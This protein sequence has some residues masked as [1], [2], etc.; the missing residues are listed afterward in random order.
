ML[1]PE[2]KTQVKVINNIV[3]SGLPLNWFNTPASTTYNIHPDSCNAQYNLDLLRGVLVKF[4][5]NKR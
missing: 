1:T 5:N 3:S 2:T 4:D